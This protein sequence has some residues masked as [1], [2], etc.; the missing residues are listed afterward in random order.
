MPVSPTLRLLAKVERPHTGV[1]IRLPLLCPVR[2]RFQVLIECQEAGECLLFRIA[3]EVEIPVEAG[4][5][6]IDTIL[7]EDLLFARGLR[8]CAF[9]P[10]GDAYATGERRSSSSGSRDL[11]NVAAA[12]AGSG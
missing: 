8:G 5:V 4:W 2:G 7:V 11:Q 12:H 10:K 9:R 6:G 3:V 1:R